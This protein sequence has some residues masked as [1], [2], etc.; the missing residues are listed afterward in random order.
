VTA[1]STSATTKTPRVRSVGAVSLARTC[2]TQDEIAAAL[3][4]SRVAV[5]QWLSGT[6]RPGP[7]KRARLFELYGIPSTDWD[8]DAGAERAPAPPM[9]PSAPPKTSS[10]AIP[11]SVH[12]KAEMLEGMARSLLESLQE[13]D[14]EGQP[15]STP[16]ERAKVMSS[17]ATTLTTIARLTGQFDVGKRLFQL[18]IW[19]AAMRTLEEALR[20]FPEAAAAVE[21]AFL[22]L[23]DQT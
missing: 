23:E 4:C 14:D 9:A 22:A 16:L 15:T 10:G 6:T 7:E 21:T 12:G 13:V 18:P 3:S 17:V 8:V 2:K 1:T 11:D 5:S 20:P 19:K